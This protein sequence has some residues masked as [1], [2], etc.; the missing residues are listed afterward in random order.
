MLASLARKR[1]KGAEMLRP[2]RIILLGFSLGIGAGIITTADASESV[3]S[4]VLVEL[5]TAEGCSSCPPADAFLVQLDHQPIQ[6]A[7]LIVLSEHM[8]YWNDSWPDAFASA[9][10]TARQADYVRALKIHSPYTPQFIID[11]ITE[12]RLSDP[13]AIEHIFRAAAASPKIPVSIASLT[14]ESGNPAHVGGQIK[15]DG[16]A[17]QRKADVYLAIAL[18]RIETKILRGENRGKTLAH[19][20]VVEYLSKVGELKPGQQFAHAFRVPLE[21]GLASND[22]R[23]IV[24]VQEPGNGKVVGAT[25]QPT[26]A[27]Q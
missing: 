5:F 25:L 15:V 21:R 22:A 16:S 17:Q 18:D 26:T 1:R 7:Q 14:A 24:F 9:Q 10:L 13:Q 27:P 19:V 11:G 4:P 2:V 12:V 8:N 23:I 3:A 20:A 6:G